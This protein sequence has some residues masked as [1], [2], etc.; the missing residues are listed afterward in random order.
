MT[1]AEWRRCA[2][3]QEMLRFLLD[4]GRASP[5]KLRLYLCAGCRHI[6][7]LFFRPESLAAVE[8]AER[9]ADGQAG[10]EELYLAGWEAE[11]ATF[12]Y[13][14]EEW[15]WRGDPPG[16]T[17]I[18]PR[19]VEMGAL[20]ESALRGGEWAVNEPVK[21]RLLA[22]AGLA[23]ACAARSPRDWYWGRHL[24][25]VDWPGSRLL[26]CVVGNPFRPLPPPA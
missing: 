9:F 2:D 22:A 23:E 4:S 11:A 10:E 3:Q 1:E 26:E 21:R 7:G 12:G 5:R 15:F 16:K 17:E 24:S 25:N 19:L 18:V 8:V 6:A 13:D 20:P 14:F